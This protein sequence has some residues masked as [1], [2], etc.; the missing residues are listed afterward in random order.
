MAG[1]EPNESAGSSDVGLVEQ[2]RVNLILEHHEDDALLADLIRAATS[3][4][5]SYQHLPDGHYDTAL[6]SASSRQGVVML[7]SHLYESRD[8]STG[9]VWNDKP[10]AAR[11][12]WG[13][14]HRLLILDRNWK[15]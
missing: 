15:I 5:C 3:Y 14:V 6:M 10:D 7:A 9:G 8:G 12:V 4:A 1:D 2:L 11:A 13:S